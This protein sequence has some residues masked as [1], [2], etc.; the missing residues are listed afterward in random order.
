MA[1][2]RRARPSRCSP[3]FSRPDEPR[4]LAVR[5]F[6]QVG[7]ADKALA[8]AVASRGGRTVFWDWRGGDHFDLTLPEPRAR[9]RGW[10]LGGFAEAVHMMLAAAHSRQMRGAPLNNLRVW[11]SQQLAAAAASIWAVCVHRRVP[12]AIEGFASNEVWLSP[13]L[14]A[15]GRHW[16]TSTAA[17]N[18][19][20]WGAR[21]A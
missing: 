9:L 21:G 3:A 10:I 17:T 6:V 14:A 4:L 19:R 7:A 13:A 11:K 5:V 2:N 20:S 18:V 15:V 1:S 8:A 16:Q 12:V